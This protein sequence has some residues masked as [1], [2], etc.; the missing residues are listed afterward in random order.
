MVMVMV[1]PIM[2][3]QAITIYMM[4]FIVDDFF[5]A[6]T[7]RT[8]TTDNIATTVLVE[9]TVVR[10]GKL[11]TGKSNV[12]GGKLW[13]GNSNVGWRKLW[14][15][16]SNKQPSKKIP[17]SDKADTIDHDLVLSRI[18]FLA[19]H[20]LDQTKIE[21]ETLATTRTGT[22]DSTATTFPVEGTVVRGGKL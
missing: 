13:T 4:I 6:A 9:G 11:W 22:T 16:K 10:G 20:T 3:K 18:L 2:P 17:S 8:G 5:S 12:R 19:S 15:K 7:I 14:T 21:V 1:I